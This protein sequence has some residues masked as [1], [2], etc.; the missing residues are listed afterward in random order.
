[1]ANCTTVP[2][3]LCWSASSTPRGRHES[4]SDSTRVQ[5]CGC[6]D[7]QRWRDGRRMTNGE[8]AKARGSECECSLED[9]HLL[10]DAAK[11]QERVAQHR[12]VWPWSNART[13]EQ[14]MGQNWQRCRLRA[15][16]ARSVNTWALRVG[17]W[18]LQVVWEMVNSDWDCWLMESTGSLATASSFRL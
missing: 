1:M 12:D 6:E 9:V 14:W 7:I 4:V 11:M 5:P 8:Y 2:W 13:H 16:G 15:L 3:R 10:W 17:W 18:S